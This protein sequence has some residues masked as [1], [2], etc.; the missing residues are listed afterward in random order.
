[1]ARQVAARLRVAG[2]DHQLDEQRGWDHGVFI[3]LK[4]MVPMADIPLVSISLHP[5][6]DPLLH[7]RIGEAL[8]ELRGQGV[9]V[10]GSGMSFHN[11]Q[12]FSH[13]EQSSMEFDAWLDRVLPQTRAQRGMDL[14]QW[15][16][17]PMA[18]AAHPRSE[19]LLPLMVCSGAGS[20]LPGI[21]DWSGKVGET[22]ISAW[23]FE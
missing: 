3:P 19:H 23:R 12:H 18:L 1:M 14:G 17:A 16:K 5:S 13:S 10:I 22:V 2:I 7:H 15:Q 8:S 21:K 9:L 20:D 4:L 11:L 6:L